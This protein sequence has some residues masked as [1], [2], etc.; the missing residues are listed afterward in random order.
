MAT[1]LIVRMFKPP[2]TTG[3]RIKA[4]AG[5]IV[6]SV[7]ISACG[8]SHPAPTATT[9]T[10][11][12]AGALLPGTGRPPVT[13]GDKNFT[14]QFVL[15]ELYLQALQAEGFNVSLDR[16]IGPTE[17]SI[18]AVAS[19]NLSMYP[20]YLDVWNESVAG[21]KRTFSSP[22]RAYGNAERYARAHGLELLLP[23]PFSDTEAIAVTGAYANTNQL[24]T[25]DDLRRVGTTLTLGA[26]PEFAQSPTGL[27]AVEQAYGFTPAAVK[28]LNIGA[29][30]QALDQ[31]TVQ[32]AYVNTTDGQL[33]NRGYRVLQ[34]PRAVFGVGNV[35]PVVSQ[36]VLA[37]EGSAFE[38]TIDSVSGLLS[39][40]VIRQLNSE[41]DVYNDDPAAVAKEFLQ[42][43]GLVPA[44][45]S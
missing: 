12:A 20:E 24:R 5:L 8:S 45:P 41:V 34:D 26:P 35:V 44:S 37:A 36:K 22:R 10:R 27:P 9:A 42:S 18:Q 2:Q 16:N 32:A 1:R 11:A 17:V 39:M 15:G 43:N 28:S 33:Y 40:R 25:L 19:G 23:T 21:S 6:I 14:E 30:Y 7:T 29:Q 31:G 38:G 3:A 13:I 4:L